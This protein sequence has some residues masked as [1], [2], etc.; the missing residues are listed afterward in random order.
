MNELETKCYLTK[1]GG[2]NS[3]D[4]DCIFTTVKNNMYCI[5]DVT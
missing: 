4:H 2:A 3:F 5:G 1:L